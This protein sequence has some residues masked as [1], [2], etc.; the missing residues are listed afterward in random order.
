MRYIGPFF[1]MNSLSQKEING[2]LFYLS[3]EAVKTIVLESK[4]GLISS[5]KSFKRLPSITDVTT[6]SNFSPLLCVYRKASPNFIHSKNS[7]GFDEDTF[8]KDINVSTNALMTLS[9]LELLDY[10]RNF[11]NIENNIYGLYH[12][13]KKLIRDQLEFYSINLRNTEGVFIDKKNLLEN[14]YKNFNLVDRDKKFKFSDQAFM[15]LAY[16]LYSHQN[17]DDELATAYNNF[18]LEILQMFI[19]YKEKIYECS[20]DEMCKTLLALNILYSYDEINEL[21]MLIIDLSDYAMSKFEDKDYYVDSLDTA[22]LCSITLSLSYKHT[23]ILTFLDKSTEIINKLST[24][25]D[26]DKE[27]FYKLSSKKEIKYS[28]FDITFYFLAFVIY[29]DVTDSKS[30]Y[31]N[32]ISSIYK[33]FFIN[34]GLIPSWPEAPTLD[35]YERYR[36]LTLS[37]EDMLDESYFRMPNLA[38]PTS[39]GIAPIFNKS[40]T[41]NKR[42]DIFSSDKTVFDSYKNFLNFYI[43]IHFFK[44][45]YMSETR[46]LSN[47]IRNEPQNKE[48]IDDKTISVNTENITENNDISISDTETNDTVD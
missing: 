3:K 46:T 27:T 10:Y 43:F 21:K 41:Y 1:R 44:D 24:L 16:Y 28:C 29:S 8:K 22:S 20:L 35:D 17:P 5:I 30:E 12:V 6:N 26:V 15:M 31:K 38:T 25:Y 45:D 4:C 2:Q 34:S 19:D 42:K 40:V 18:S 36:G 14:N 48:S 13:Y 23:N 7:N 32:L 39:A 9:L 11:E 37:S 33:K 47:I